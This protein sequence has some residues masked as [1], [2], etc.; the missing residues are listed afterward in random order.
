MFK[1]LKKI[2]DLQAEIDAFRPFSK[3]LLALWQERLRIDWT[4]NSNAIEGNTLTY[5]ETAFFLRE[6]LTSEG[7]PLKDYVEAKNHAEAIDYLQEVV[8][9]KR[10]LTEGFI[11]ELHGLLLR[12]I[13]HTIAKGAG[14][15][16][17][18]KPLSAGKYK[19]RPN[20]VLT[21]SGTIHKYT[22]P[23][24]VVD[25]MQELLTEFDKNKKL[26]LVERAALFHYRF[27]CIHPFD[28]GNGRMAR[29]LMNL[30]LM[31]AGYPP[32]VVRHIRRR[33]YLQSLEHA[34]STGK[35]DEFIRLLASELIQT[36]ET[37]LRVLEGKPLPPIPGEKLHREA[38]R[39]LILKAIGTDTLSIGQIADRVQRIKRPTLKNDLS[40]LVRAKKLRKKGIGKGVI[41]TR[42]ESA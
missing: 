32:C 16:L 4:Y 22:E 12:D 3:E 36:E 18:H 8:Q 21:L 41:Y 20:H 17:I 26:H 2:D 24:K 5:G 15:K 23:I 19:V 38:R 29:L 40:A 27:V 14:G 7:K 31:Q 6:G 25:E 1:E 11:K 33:E 34:D 9:S 37:M 35:T 30:L 13:D 10:T 28:D 42:A 39:E